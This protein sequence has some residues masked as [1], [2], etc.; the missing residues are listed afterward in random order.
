MTNAQHR[1]QK[2]LRDI[3]VVKSSLLYKPDTKWG[4][5]PAADAEFE[6][7]VLD[8]FEYKMR[9]D[10]EEDLEFQQPIPY[11]IIKNPKLNKFVAYKRGS[12][13]STSGETRLF[14]K[15]SL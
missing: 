8:N 6:Q 5:I 11:V 4:F 3:L 9:G 1:E 2:M 13:E 10:M 15:W 7:T 12:S 14:G